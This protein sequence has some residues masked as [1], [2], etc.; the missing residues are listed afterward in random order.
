MPDHDRQCGRSKIH[1]HIMPLCLQGI[2]ATL[3]V[4]S[5]QPPE[6][7]LRSFWYLNRWHD[8]VKLITRRTLVTPQRSFSNEAMIMSSGAHSQDKKVLVQNIRCTWSDVTQNEGNEAVSCSSFKGRSVIIFGFHRLLLQVHSRLS[9]CCHAV[10][11]R[12]REEPTK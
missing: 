8:S 2:P 10:S 12:D 5:G 7:E 1:Q 6:K 3:Q 4:S 9:I 11:R